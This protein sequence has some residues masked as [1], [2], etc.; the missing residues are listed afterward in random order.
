MTLDV[1]AAASGSATG[2]A[3]G[4]VAGGKTCGDCGSE[5]P[6][7]LLIF[8]QTAALGSTEPTI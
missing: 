8:S 5:S 4:A 3:G 1:T 6:T 2:A 7:A